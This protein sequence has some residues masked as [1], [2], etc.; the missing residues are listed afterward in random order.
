MWQKMWNE[1]LETMA[2]LSQ[3]ALERDKLASQ[4]QY[5]FANS[6]FVRRKF[7]E[8][9]LKPEDISRTE[10]LSRL[11]FTTKEE[12][13]QSQKEAPPFGDYLAASR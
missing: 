12:L 13:R 1:E 9:G 5:V 6:P 10:G 7:D 3:T 8:A 2:P 11:P 4:L